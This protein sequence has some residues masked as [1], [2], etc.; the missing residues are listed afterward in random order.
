MVLGSPQ[1]QRGVPLFSSVC[2]C[3]AGV[4]NLAFKSKTMTREWV[5]Q[6]YARDA[7]WSIYCCSSVLGFEGCPEGLLLRLSERLSAIWRRPCDRPRNQRGPTEQLLVPIFWKL[8]SR[9]KE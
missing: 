4:Q 8:E 6:W 3:V 1:R 5:D 9:A 2:L 7:A